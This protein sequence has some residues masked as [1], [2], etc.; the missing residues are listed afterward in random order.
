MGFFEWHRHQAAPLSKTLFFSASGI[1]GDRFRHFYAAFG[2][3][4]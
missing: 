2:E 1:P 4:A 3:F